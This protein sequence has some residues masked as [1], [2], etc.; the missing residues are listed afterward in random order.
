MFVVCGDTLSYRASYGALP[1]LGFSITYKRW[2]ADTEL[3]VALVGHSTLVGSPLCLFKKGGGQ[4][5]RCFL[6][7]ERYLLKPVCGASPVLL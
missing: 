1:L 3:F 5:R 2:C 4:I 7:F 6:N